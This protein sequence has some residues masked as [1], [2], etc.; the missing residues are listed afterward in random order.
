MTD[1]TNKKKR[2]LLLPPVVL[3][4]S[5]LLCF[6]L[7]HWLP[8]AE[9][10]SFAGRIIGATTI[11]AALAMVFYCA[12]EF[13]SRQTTIIPFQESAAL[14]TGG[15]YRFSRNPIYLGMAALLAGIAI[16]LGSASPWIVPPLFM[17]IITIRFIQKEEASLTE[18][19][20]DE[21]LEYTQRVRRWL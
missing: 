11:A 6:A 16:L 7:S 1:N 12:L 3:L 19:F 8:I 2:P 14:I 17:A 18:T 15:L 9:F 13:R 4:F 21:Y 20:G 10:G 5:V